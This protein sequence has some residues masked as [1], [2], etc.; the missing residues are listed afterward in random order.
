MEWM[1]LP[2]GVTDFNPKP[3]N[4]TVKPQKFNSLKDE[5]DFFLKL[6]AENVGDYPDSP[7]KRVVEWIKDE[8]KR[9]KAFSG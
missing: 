7:I 2:F 1:E 9:K 4:D 3:V 6:S 5:L 8:I